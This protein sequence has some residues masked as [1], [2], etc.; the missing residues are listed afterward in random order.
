[1]PF[2]KKIKLILAASMLLVAITVAIPNYFVSNNRQTKA[3]SIELNTNSEIKSQSAEDGDI[4]Q[5]EKPAYFN[6]F[7]FIFSFLPG[8]R[9]GKKIIS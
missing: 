9:S 4:D 1:M 8:N 7:N 5:V 6:L 2:T 3:A